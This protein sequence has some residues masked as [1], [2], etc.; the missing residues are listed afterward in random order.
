MD[1]TNTVNFINTKQ[2]VAYVAGELSNKK[3]FQVKDTV[4]SSGKTSPYYCDLRLILS[5]PQLLAVITDYMIYTIK[6]HTLVFDRIASV[7]LGSVPF[8]SIVASKMELPSVM[9][10]D[11]PKTYG[12]KRMFEGVI[13]VDD[14][15]LL[16]EDVITTGASVLETITKIKNRG[17][18]VIGV[19][20]ILDRQEGGAENIAYYHPDIPVY[21]LFT[22]SSLLS[23][24]LINKLIVD[25]D[26]ERIRF[27][28]DCQYKEMLHTISK[29]NNEVLAVPEY[30][31][32][33]IAF[34]SAR[35][36]LATDVV[37]RRPASSAANDIILDFTEY[38]N[39]EIIKGNI[40]RARNTVQ[41]V[42]VSDSLSLDELDE[43]SDLRDKYKFNL[44]LNTNSVLGMPLELDLGTIPNEYGYLADYV[45]NNVV[46]S[47]PGDMDRVITE[48]KLHATNNDYRCQRHKLIQFTFTNSSMI[49]NEDMWIKFRDY[50]LSLNIFDFIVGII[51]NLSEFAQTAIPKKLQ[52][53]HWVPVFVRAKMCLDFHLKK[54]G[55]NIVLSNFITSHKPIGF[56]IG[57]DI[58]S[59][60]VEINT[61]ISEYSAVVHEHHKNITDQF[62]D[63]QR[64]ACMNISS[65]MHNDLLA[66][67]EQLIDPTPEVKAGKP[68]FWL[69][70]PVSRFM[71]AIGTLTINWFSTLTD[72]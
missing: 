70:N 40:I 59:S 7:P 23:S 55:D 52:I 14:N 29:R 27:F 2:T 49:S 41:S 63:E 20:C 43:I 53:A 25:Y 32:D 44:I 62:N 67:R 15:V 18:N 10:R 30:V 61:R 37:G 8:A 3:V 17:A 19:L 60:S 51:F 33:P 13:N 34:C 9:V 1:N 57:E 45:I 16:I 72:R 5:Y 11:K 22:V 48:L 4:L 68:S 50:L 39:L 65:K 42:I 12:S 47:H 58:I 66:K 54:D 6:E 31:K 26:A 38:D 56:I 28:Q 64:T 35:Y 21:S 46:I 36:P 24:L 71:G 69:N